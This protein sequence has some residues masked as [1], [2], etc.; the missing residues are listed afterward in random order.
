MLVKYPRTL[1]VPWSIG[2]T[3]DDR[4]LQNMDGFQNQEVVV[5]EKLDGENTSLYKDAMHARSLS[6]MHHPSRTWVKT[7]QGSIGYRIP[8][9]WR[10]CGENVYACHSIHY[11][12]LTSYFYV[13]SI[14]NEKNECLS[15]DETVVWCEKLGLVHVPVLYRGPYNE[16]AIRS[17]YSGKSIFGGIQEGYVLRFTETFHYDDFSQSVGKFVRK[18]HVQTNKHWMTQTVIPNQLAK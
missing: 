4:V 2:I 16:K 6:S 17:C 12:E 8:E 14:W 9:G 7:L 15:W 13:F 5:L 18:D 3:S 10:I 11:T 1:H